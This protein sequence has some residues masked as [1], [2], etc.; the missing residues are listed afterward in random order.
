[1]LQLCAG[2]F[3]EDSKEKECAMKANSST[4]LSHTEFHEVIKALEAAIEHLKK[5]TLSS[6]QPKYKELS[7][8]SCRNTLYTTGRNKQVY[9]KY[10]EK[11]VLQRLAKEESVIQ[12]VSKVRD[13]LRVLVLVKG[14]VGYIP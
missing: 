11:K 5:L 8:I 1:M 14:I 6:I 4:V 12:F 10:D 2:I 9:Y 3:D 13:R 7:Q